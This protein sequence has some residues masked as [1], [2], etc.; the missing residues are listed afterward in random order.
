[1]GDHTRTLGGGDAASAP[2]PPPLERGSRLGRYV[3]DRLLGAGGMGMVYAARDPSLER[4]VAVKLIR[5]ASDGRAALV[6]WSRLIGE[7]RAM[8]RLSHPNVVTVFEAGTDQGQAF[9][10]MEL[11]DGLTLAEWLA[12]QRRPWRETV[13]MCLQA[14]RGLAAAHAAGVVHRDFKPSNVLVSRSGVARVT[15]FGLAQLRD[16]AGADGPEAP[17]PLE[18]TPAY[19]APE[20][21]RGAPADARTDQYAFCAV[22]HE[23]LHGTLPSAGSPGTARLPRR[24]QRLLQRGLSSDPGARYPSMEALLDELEV[25]ARAPARKVWLAAVAAGAVL[26]AGAFP[27]A[28]LLEQRRCAEAERALDGVWEGAA[29]EDVRRAFLATG[30]PIAEDAFASV[31][32]TLSRYA[33]E[34]RAV[35]LETCLAARVRRE[36][37]DRAHARAAACLAARRDG[38]G[39]VVRLLGAADQKVVFEA[40]TAVHGLEPVAACADLQGQGPEAGGPEGAGAGP[41]V[42]RARQGISEV[43]ALLHTGQWAKAAAGAPGVVEAARAAGSRALEAEAL[44]AAGAAYGRAGDFRAAEVSLREAVWASQAGRAELLEARAWIE[45]LGLV[46][47]RM[48]PEE[49]ER[50]R[51]HAVATLERVGGHPDLEIELALNSGDACSAQLRHQDAL[52]ANRKAMELA[53]RRFGADSWRIAGPANNVGAALMAVGRYQEALVFHRRALAA[54]EHEYGPRHADVAGS[55]HNIARVYR[56][57]GRPD[58]ALGYAARAMEIWERSLGK[59]HPRYGRGAHN[60]AAILSRLGRHQEALE[61]CR[62]SLGVIERSLGAGHPEE[63]PVRSLEGAVLGALGQR[64]AAL[65]A[66]RRAVEISERSGNPLALAAA[67]VEQGETLD[68]AGR[69][70]GAVEAGRRAL[71]ALDRGGAPPSVTHARAGRLIARAALASGKIDEGIAKLLDARSVYRQAAGEDHPDV[72]L[73]GLEVAEALVGSGGDR[74]Q[75]RRLAEEAARM[76]EGAGEPYRARAAVARR[77]AGSPREARPPGAR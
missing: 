25:L 4:D 30:A 57:W 18:G 5:P 76:L 35:T 56:E 29:R 32:R 38:L 44:L 40:P 36:R 41:E 74:D 54:R 63:G 70:A 72:G 15:D 49:G 21:L 42:A 12:H 58:Q 46:G 28:R 48:A 14:G 1:M 24:L 19:M 39:Q 2:A 33:A 64:E 34:W 13:R 65:A 31:D 45:L 71:E 26:G 69:S 60:M 55:L 47:G 23:A 61:W 59:D 53:E 75:A 68:A 17:A 8:A 11:V 51:R 22:L 43:K 50:L 37:S 9:L 7:A 20:Q 73:W 16:V 52:E 77:L 67:L 27:A 6:R 66:H 62:V 10:A 3:L